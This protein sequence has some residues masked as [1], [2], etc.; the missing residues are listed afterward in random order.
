MKL[1]NGESAKLDLRKIHDY[2]LS[3]FHPRGKHKARVFELVLGLTAEDFLFLAGVLQRVAIENEAIEGASDKYGDRF[4]IDFDLE[5]K[6]RTAAIR[7]CWIVLA[8]E[9]VP[10][11][12]TCYIL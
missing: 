3:P 6:E 1:P 12:V 10:R 7:S 4:I 5:H 8:G 2:S 9:A 11:F